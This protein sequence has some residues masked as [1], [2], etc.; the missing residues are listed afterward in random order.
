MRIK[1]YTYLFLIKFHLFIFYLMC[2]CPC[3]YTRMVI[4]AYMYWPYA[5]SILCVNK[6]KGD[7][8]VKKFY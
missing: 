7:E 8:I 3:S 1:I 6:G 5:K 2:S 4:I